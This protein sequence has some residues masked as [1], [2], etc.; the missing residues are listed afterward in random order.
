M[1]ATV[2]ANAAVSRCPMLPG[3]SGLGFVSAICSPSRCS[4]ENRRP[5][6]RRKSLGASP[7]GCY[8]KMAAFELRPRLARNYTH[9]ARETPRC[10]TI[11]PP[12]NRH[13]RAP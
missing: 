8:L 13:E 1:P 12:S 3:I 5:S 7:S 2:R 10:P 9:A 4:E 11:I 6:G